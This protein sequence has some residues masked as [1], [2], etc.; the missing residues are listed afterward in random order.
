MSVRM[1]EKERERAKASKV[2]RECDTRNMHTPNVRS[3]MRS[4]A[5]FYF[6][7]SVVANAI[8][9]SEDVMQNKSVGMNIK[10]TYSCDSPPP[11]ERRASEQEIECAHG[12]RIS[13]LE[14]N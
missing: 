3:E 11:C 5:R 6:A 1:G 10:C 14:F 2:K 4:H 13:V 9:V 12:V 8:E 7:F